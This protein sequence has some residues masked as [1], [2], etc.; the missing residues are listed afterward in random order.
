[1]P[2][3]TDKSRGYLRLAVVNYQRAGDCDGP[4][5]K[6]NFSSL[7]ASMPNWPC[8][9]MIPLGGARSTHTT[10]PPKKRHA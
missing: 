4:E 1:V 8:N 3:Y 6:A 9:S 10:L 5:P 2:G 7:H